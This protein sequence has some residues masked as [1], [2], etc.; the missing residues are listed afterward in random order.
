MSVQSWQIPCPRCGWANSGAHLRCSKCGQPLGARPGLLVAGQSLSG[1]GERPISTK[2]AKP[3]GFLPRLIALIIDS[4]ILLVVLFPVTALWSLQLAPVKVESGGAASG[5]DVLR[6]SIA[7]Q[8]TLTV[9]Y[10]FYFA[11]SWTI[12][13]ATPGQLLMSLRV[14]DQN[15]AGIGFFRAVFRYILYILLSPLAIVSA[16]LVIA[17]KNKRALHDMLAGTYVIQVLDR[18]DLTAE[19]TGLPA[20]FGG[21]GKKAEAVPAPIAPAPAPAP[22]P[23]PAPVAAAPAAAVYQA[24][25]TPAYN[26]APAP[27]AY[28][29]PPMA[30]PAPPAA[31]VPPMEFPAMPMGPVADVPPPP[32]HHAPGS[33]DEGLYAPPP[34]M[35]PTPSLADFTAPAP[36][37]PAAREIYTPQPSAPPAPP[38]PPHEG[39]TPPFDFPPMAPPPEPHK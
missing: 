22:A 39:E 25:P 3:G 20:A 32:S 28:S 21:G 8:L 12:M 9:L 33:G 17:G 5:V 2:V 1:K 14:T 7:L 38:A 18:D 4:L 27:A 11:G 35:D 30:D 19:S 13:G 29:P 16:L 15:A 24:P 10:L 26:P 36:A 34:M 31:S 37:A 23:P 6:G